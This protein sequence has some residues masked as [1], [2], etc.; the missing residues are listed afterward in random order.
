MPQALY[1]VSR[2]HIEAVPPQVMTVA[3]LLRDDFLDHADPVIARWCGWLLVA[4]A[5]SIPLGTATTN[6]LGAMLLIALILAGGY[7][8]HWQRWRMHPFALVTLV[9]CAVIFI[10]VSYSNAPSDEIVRALKKYARLLYAP[11]AIAV[12]VDERWRRRALLAWMASMLLTL[13]LSY[14]HA[15][16]AFP[17]ARS[18]RENELNDHYIFKHHITQNVMMS[19][20]AVA[21]FAEAWRLR[22]RA[23]GRWRIYAWMGVAFAAAVNILFFVWGRAG[24]LT[25]FVNLLVVALVAFIAARDTRLTWVAAGLIVVAI[26]AASTSDMVHQRFQAA[27]SEVESSQERGITTSI[28][29]RIEYASKSVDLIEARPILGW[30]TGSYAMEYCRIAKSPEWCK[31][32]SYNPHNQFLFFAVQFGVLG[33]LA[34][35]AWLITAGVSMRRLPICEQLVGYSVLA[36]LVVHSLLDSPLYI[37][38]EGAW[39]PLMLGVFAAGAYPPSSERARSP[40]MSTEGHSG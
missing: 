33:V 16:W 6:I 21:A 4:V 18:T 19:V 31:L 9:L 23:D 25:L 20:F 36:T 5:A 32:G 1:N 10:G 14:L 26:G 17:L 35:V 28:G 13:L 12:L 24:Y 27:L 38:T 11:I 30:G 40:T 22:S 29:Q 8:A 15:V 3:R 2:E 34:L 7:K 39:Y 37:V